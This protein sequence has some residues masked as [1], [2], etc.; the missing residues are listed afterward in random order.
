MSGPTVENVIKAAERVKGLV[1][2]TPV[3]TSETMD[4]RAKRELFFKCE[5]LQKGAQGC[6]SGC[7]ERGC[8]RHE[9]ERRGRKR[10][11]RKREEEERR[12]RKTK[13]TLVNVFQFGAVSRDGKRG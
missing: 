1:H 13:T 10:E 4:A 5:H 3:L 12:L 11:E 2:R 7:R 6:I 9:E 8:W